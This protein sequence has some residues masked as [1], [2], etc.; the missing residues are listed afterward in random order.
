MRRTPLLFAGRGN[1]AAQ[2]NYPDKGDKDGR[3]NFTACQRPIGANPL[4][5]EPRPQY[6]MRPPFVH[7]ESGV[8]Y[9]EPCALDC[10]AFDERVGDRV[11]MSLFEEDGDAEAA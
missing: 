9:C 2:S 1:V 8:F 6:I 5:S 4:L 11:R 10:I 3:C 7:F